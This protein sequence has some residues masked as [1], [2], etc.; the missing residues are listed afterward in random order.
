MARSQNDILT[1]L[2]PIHV[3]YPP[4]M[5]LTSHTALTHNINII[6]SLRNSIVNHFLS[7]SV[8]NLLTS[9]LSL[10]TKS[11]GV[12]LSSHINTRNSLALTH[13]TLLPLPT[14]S[15]LSILCLSFLISLS[16]LPLL[17]FHPS[18]NPRIINSNTT[19]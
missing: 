13:S 6:Y 17:L 8:L 14:L 1:I 16:F 2:T 5:T 11:K 10:S 12:R 19:S 15:F 4:L 7:Y 3:L 9:S 18:P